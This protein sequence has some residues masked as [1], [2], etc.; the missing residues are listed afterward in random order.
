MKKSILLI[1]VLILTLAVG[2]GA[3]N[4]F[5]LADS[6]AEF[7]DPYY[8]LT[9]YATNYVD[10]TECTDKEAAAAAFLANTLEG[11]GYQGKDGKTVVPF[12]FREQDMSEATSVL[13]ATKTVEYTS[14]NVVAYK[15]SSQS[16]APLL[17]FASN[18]G[19]GY[20][21]EYLGNTLK[22]QEVY[23]NATSVAVLLSLAYKLSTTDLP[24]DLA[25]CFWGADYYGSYGADA[26]WQS[27]T[28]KVLGY[29]QVD[30]I[31]GGDHVNLYC[32]EVGSKHETYLLDQGRKYIDDLHT[33]PFDAGYSTA[34]S[35]LPYVHP[36]L[37]G[38]NGFFMSKGV[39]S[40]YLFGYNW[41]GGLDNSES[42]KA[43][44]VLGT[45]EDTLVNLERNYGKDKVESRLNQVVTYLTAVATDPQGVNDSFGKDEQP[46]YWALVSDAAYHGFK[47][48]VVGIAVL[49]IVI[50][51][52]L[53][54]KRSKRADVP[55]FTATQSAPTTEEDVFE[56]GEVADDASAPTSQEEQQ[57]KEQA[58]SQDSGDDDIFG[59]Y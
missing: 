43:P 6:V 35:P 57:T 11:M 22:A 25:F 1:F 58:P 32:D 56:Q 26:F 28:Q 45:S 39:P 51:A 3:G 52:V 34:V 46:A 2:F 29:I 38:S 27:N 16:D 23:G 44:S 9:Y 33:M 30:A 41:A 48:S 42:A 50:V 20:Q 24:Y 53:L 40:A 37:G 36:G 4:A 10:R 31:G 55:D 19:N 17:I 47:W 8:G 15:R 12:T 5:A 7:G 54:T 18:Y 59:E 14:R 13:L 49:A 21:T